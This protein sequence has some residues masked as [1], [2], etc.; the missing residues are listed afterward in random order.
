MFQIGLWKLQKTKKNIIFFNNMDN[1]EKEEKLTVISSNQELALALMVMAANSTVEHCDRPGFIRMYIK[2]FSIFHGT[3]STDEV[4]YRFLISSSDKL[5]FGIVTN[6]DPSETIGGTV[7][8]TLLKEKP[9]KIIIKQIQVDPGVVHFIINDRQCLTEMSWADNSWM[10]SMSDPES[11]DIMA[12]NHM[13]LMDEA[14][15]FI[16]KPATITDTW[17]V[18]Q[19]VKHVN[20]RLDE[21][22]K[23]LPDGHVLEE[24][25]ATPLENNT[26]GRFM[27]LEQMQR[28]LEELGLDVD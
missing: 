3:T 21:L 14:V 11:C 4:L 26:L 28:F 17:R 24:R 10:F 27:E 2:D 18:E 13:A 9:N 20:R 23:K 6:N 16:F 22:W 19:I 7:F 25:E 8:E 15:D 5:A 12:M 1:N